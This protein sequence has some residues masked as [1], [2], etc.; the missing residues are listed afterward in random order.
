MNEL[1]RI[2][3]DVSEEIE[4]RFSCNRDI[5][6]VLHPRSKAKNEQQCGNHLIAVMNAVRNLTPIEHENY[7][8][9]NLVQYI[10]NVPDDVP[11]ERIV[12][13][14][15]LVFGEVLTINISKALKKLNDSDVLRPFE[16]CHTSGE[17][18]NNYGPVKQFID[19]SI[20]G[21]EM[22]HDS[23]KH[24]VTEVLKGSMKFSFFQ[25]FVKCVI[26]SQYCYHCLG[27]IL[28]SLENRNLVS[29]CI[30]MLA[31]GLWSPKE[32]KRME[33]GFDWRTDDNE[34]HKYS[35]WRLEYQLARPK[36]SR[37]TTFDNEWGSFSSTNFSIRRG[38][39]RSSSVRQF[40]LDCPEI[41]DSFNYFNDREL[42][43]A[44]SSPTYDNDDQLE[45]DYEI[46]KS[47]PKRVEINVKKRRNTKRKAS[48]RGVEGEYE[49]PV[50]KKLSV[51]SKQ[52]VPE[53]LSPRRVIKPRSF[54]AEQNHIITNSKKALDVDNVGNVSEGEDDDVIHVTQ[55][56]IWN[57][58]KD[59]IIRRAVESG[60]RFSR[61]RESS[62]SPPKN[63]SAWSRNHHRMAVLGSRYEAFQNFKP[64]FSKKANGKI[65]AFEI[66]CVEPTPEKL[67]I[68]EESQEES[69]LDSGI[70]SLFSSSSG[71]LDTEKEALPEATDPSI[72]VP[73]CESSSED[74]HD[75]VKNK[76][77]KFRYAEEFAKYRRSPPRNRSQTQSQDIKAQQSNDVITLD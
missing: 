45:V 37:E 59:V 10:E 56:E 29:K 18:L 11:S 62:L 39:G 77:Q 22:D 46:E 51:E 54:L 74:S 65:I 71:E 64:E 16:V 55:E 9:L 24:A 26:Y 38:E 43:R 36:F 44:R 12:Y 75:S 61:A 67:S 72:M 57:T 8:S 33:L 28:S 30:S 50:T 13:W 69:I 52:S 60:F 35:F 5:F 48:A 25:V 76:R 7:P 31:Q 40:S 23:L 27:F 4:R 34:K 1:K 15:S 32:S 68:Y 14:N 63:K 47:A 66:V 41:D 20:D 42:Y 49:I 6:V 73:S 3:R 53:S 2:S 70:S 21:H 58:T 17:F 19:F